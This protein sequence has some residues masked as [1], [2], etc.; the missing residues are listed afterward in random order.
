MTPVSRR[1]GPQFLEPDRKVFPLLQVLATATGARSGPARSRRAAARAPASAVS[2]ARRGRRHHHPR[3]LFGGEVATS[4]T[5]CA[6]PRTPLALSR[7]PHP[8]H[9]PPTLIA[10]ATPPCTQPNTCLPTTTP[11][12]PSR[13]AAY[14]RSREAVSPLQGSRA[15]RRGAQRRR[16]GQRGLGEPSGARGEAQG[17]RR[18]EIRRDT[19]ARGT[20]P[21]RVSHTDNFFF[22]AMLG[23][24]SCVLSFSSLLRS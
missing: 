1:L 14:R 4:T 23:A 21:D 9:P 16:R 8:P 3:A 18:R 15:A 17:R 13:H 24:F 6:C 20:H 10:H 7:A 2:P 11:P 5:R 12:H 22:Q 19:G